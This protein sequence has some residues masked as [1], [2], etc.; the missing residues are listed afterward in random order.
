[1]RDELSSFEQQRRNLASTMAEE[2]NAIKAEHATA[3]GQ[4]QGQI[5]EL[6]EQL[7][8]HRAMAAAQA[9]ETGGS[10]LRVEADADV[11][12]NDDPA[13]VGGDGFEDFPVSPTAFDHDGPGGFGEDSFSPFEA[14]NDA[15]AA[16][17]AAAAAAPAAPAAPASSV[18]AGF[19]PFEPMEFGAEED[20]STTMNG[21]RAPAAYTPP[22]ALAVISSRDRLGFVTTVRS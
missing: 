6:Q 19:S 14:D 4:L 22:I 8:Q 20:S 21:R 17:A 7:A 9:A 13:A 12:G 11:F 2:V 18:P 1:M 15:T 3:E 5:A 10:A 16:A